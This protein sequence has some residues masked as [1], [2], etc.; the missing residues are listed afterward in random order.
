MTGAKDENAAAVIAAAYKDGEAGAEDKPRVILQNAADIKPEP[1]QWLWLDW[2]ARRKL[3][4]L[5]GSPGTGKTTIALS[6]AATISAGGKFP[7]GR[8]ATPGKVLMWSGEDDPRDT[9]I[10]RLMAAKADLSKIEFVGPVVEYDM[11]QQKNVVVPFDP[12]RDIEKLATAV[13]TIDDLALIVIDPIVSAVIGDSHNNGDVRRGLMPLGK[14]AEARNAALL[15]ITHYTKGTQGRDP[16]ERV[17]GSLAF[18]AAARFVF[19]TAKQRQPEGEDA[20]TRFIMARVKS[21]IGQDGGGFEY[22]FEQV[23]IDPRIP[24]NRIKWGEAISGDP[25]ALIADAEADPD[26]DEQDAVSWLRDYM[27][28]GSKAATDMYRDGRAQGYSKDQVKRAKKKLHLK[29]E[30]EKGSMTG[31]WRWEL[32]GAGVPREGKD[33]P[34]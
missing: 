33:V 29:K 24:A 13:A 6:W 19:G 20:E 8:E 31:G 18:G 15:G 26:D 16:L 22:Q 7:D 2:L 5:A 17:T 25:R 21:S 9:L 11:D 14:L 4:I 23:E 28:D 1:I 30:K 32:P 27:S 10:P 12:A 34:F 3:H